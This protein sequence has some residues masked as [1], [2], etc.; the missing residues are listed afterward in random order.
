MQGVLSGFPIP[1]SNYIGSLVVSRM[2][3]GSL[4]IIETQGMVRCWLN[5]LTGISTLELIPLIIWVGHGLG[6]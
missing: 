2:K 5:G 3:M 4:T 6:R 1:Q